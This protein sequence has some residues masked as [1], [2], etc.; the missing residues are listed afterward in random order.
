[1][2]STFAIVVCI[3]F[4]TLS[5]RAARAEDAYANVLPGC[6][7][8]NAGLG[9]MIGWSFGE[10]TKGQRLFGGFEA[11]AGCPWLRLS[12]GA[13]Y[14]RAPRGTARESVYWAAYDPGLLAGGSAGVSYSSQ[15]GVQALLGAWLGM[16]SPLKFWEQYV[17]PEHGAHGLYRTVCASLSVGVRVRFGGDV[18]RTDLYVTPK[19][20]YCTYPQ[21]NT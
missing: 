14:R 18:K 6:G 8:L 12:L 1:M 21:F 20:Q 4:L 7:F 2:R 5:P 19:F 16:A 3:A 9:P 13:T 17:E 10:G 15:L 11:S